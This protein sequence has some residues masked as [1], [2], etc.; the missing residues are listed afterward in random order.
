[1]PQSMPPPILQAI[2]RRQADNFIREQQQG[3]G[4]PIVSTEFHGYRVVAVGSTIHWSKSW[5]TFHDFLLDY[6]KKILGEKWGNSEISKRFEDRH[7]ILQWYELVC[8]AQRLTVREPGQVTS[9]PMTGAI[10]AYL[11]LAYYLYLL[12]HNTKNNEFNLTIQRKVVKDLKGRDSFP[13]AFYEAFVFSVLI[14]AGYEIKFE[15]QSGRMGKRCECVAIHKSTGKSFTVEAKSIRRAGSLGA[16]DNTTQKPLEG[17]LRNQL[18]DALSKIS[19]HPRIVFIDLNLPMLNEQASLADE[20]AEI[21]TRA[22]DLTVKGKPTDPAYVFLTNFPHHYHVSEANIGQF[23]LAAGYKLADFGHGKHFAS[24]RAMYAAKRKHNEI[25]VII[26]SMRTHY[27]IPVTYDGSLPSET[28]GDSS[29]RLRIGE[30]YFFDDLGLEATVTTA[31]VDVPNKTLY[32]GTDNG[33]IIT[34]EMSDAEVSDYLK[35]P[36]AYFGQVTGNRARPITDP[37]EMFEWL[38]ESY[39]QTPT[40][41]LLEFM[42]GHPK[43]DQLRELAQ[44]ELLEI[45]CEGVVSLMANRAPMGNSPIQS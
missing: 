41:K 3:R 38:L 17:S 16:I 24:L 4:H 32:A 14:R 31:T 5:M 15:D 44:P 37:F 39:E 6:V 33:H 19:E 36:S 13:G 43:M 1:M 18:Y 22:E 45:Y 2:K 9:A 29:S 34:R 30:R 27:E 23:A 8:Q 28:Y 26:D 42:R 7:P 12:A 35:H 25:H 10:Q 21:L 40:A 11:N 20:C